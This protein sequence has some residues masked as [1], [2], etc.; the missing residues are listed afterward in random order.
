MAM[1]AGR[2]IDIFHLADVTDGGMFANSSTEA[3]IE[4]IDIGTEFGPGL[5]LL[6]WL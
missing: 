4:T 3:E 1:T 2:A 6:D 5:S